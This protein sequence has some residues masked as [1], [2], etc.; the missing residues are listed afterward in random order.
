[1]VVSF[2][3]KLIEQGN[4]KLCAESKEHLVAQYVNM[5]PALMSVVPIDQ[6]NTILINRVS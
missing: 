2:F 3:L 6:T 5:I 1:M 4:H